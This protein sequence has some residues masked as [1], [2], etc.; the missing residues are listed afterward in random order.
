MMA[1]IAH[2]G[3]L[4]DVGRGYT[5]A[6]LKRALVTY[7]IARGLNGVI[8]VA[9]GT[10][11]AVEPGGVGV[12]FKPGEVLDPINDLIE[13][14]SWIVLASSTS[15]GMQRVM[16]NV[17][18]W[19]WFSVAVTLALLTALT[20]LWRPGWF[21]PGMQRVLWKL[22]AVMLLVRFCVPMIAIGSEQFYTLFLAPQYQESNQQ[23][24]A[25]SD[26]LKA[27]NER[28]PN[29]SPN[30]NMSLLERARET[31]RSTR[32]AIDIN[33]RV[34]AFKKAAS[35]I[36]GYTVNLIVVFI[37]ETIVFP[38]LFLWVVLQLIKHTV[39]W[40]PAYTGAS[41]NG[42]ERVGDH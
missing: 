28:V 33:Q 26:R 8:S 24:N 32:E 21:A 29:Q 40:T 23:L 9:Q 14:F 22:A 15:L 4:D 10:E 36:A 31:L 35:N 34:D 13:R 38:L 39:A 19:P 16:L 37:L 11:I 1:L 25:A 2:L 3:L 27:L 41:E 6:G 12:T 17:T 5:D 42:K 20:C 7:G 30:A 18:A